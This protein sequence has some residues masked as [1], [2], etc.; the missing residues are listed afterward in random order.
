MGHGGLGGPRL[1]A[2][3]LVAELEQGG[4]ITRHRDGH[5]NRYALHDGQPLRH[6]LENSHTV[7]QLLELLSPAG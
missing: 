5:R 1:I 3:I 6:S 2:V 7:D 4:Y